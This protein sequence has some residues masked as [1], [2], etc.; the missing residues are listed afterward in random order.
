MVGQGERES[1]GQGRIGVTG[2]LVRVE[3]GL[4]VP[5][6]GLPERVGRRPARRRPDSPVTALV[7]A[8]EAEG[9]IG[10]DGCG[11]SCHPDDHGATGRHRRWSHAMPGL[12]PAGYCTVTVPLMDG[13]M[14][15]R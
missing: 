5:C 14:V 2:S 11:R 9:E 8:A 10:Q 13:W 12:P 1:G 4:L 7:V 3:Q 6:C 15:H